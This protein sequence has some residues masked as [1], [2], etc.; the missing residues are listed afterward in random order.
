M[1]RFPALAFVLA[2]PLVSVTV[3]ADPV[4]GADFVYGSVLSGPIVFDNAQVSLANT[5]GFG[6]G[7]SFASLA[8][9]VLR[10]RAEP[11]AAHAYG[12]RS[13][14][15]LGVAGQHTRRHQCF[16]QHF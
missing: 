10:V 2:L 14:R 8:D 6:T 12:R 15:T 5:I 7:T 11:V 1:L 3:H 13:C 4:P 16:E 9:G